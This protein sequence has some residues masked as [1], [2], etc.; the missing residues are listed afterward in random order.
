VGKQT[1]KMTKGCYENPH[2]FLEVIF[3]WTYSAVNASKMAG[4]L[5]QKEQITII[6]LN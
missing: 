2:T 6:M 4:I 5:L 3:K 1:V